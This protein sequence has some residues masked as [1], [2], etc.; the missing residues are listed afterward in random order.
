MEG[1]KER[2]KEEKKYKSFASN[3]E[4]K[5]INNNNK[6]MSIM[7]AIACHKVENLRFHEIRRDRQ[8]VVVVF[9]LA[10]NC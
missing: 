2:K 4:D 5:E 1:L 7:V 6:K 3:S 8:L 9:H 10:E